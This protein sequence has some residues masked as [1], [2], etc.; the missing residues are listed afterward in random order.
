MSYLRSVCWAV[1]ESTLRARQ[2][3]LAEPYQADSANEQE[4]L[5]RS[6]RTFT[7][8][9]VPRCPLVLFKRGKRKWRL[10]SR[11]GQHIKRS[12]TESTTSLR[13]RFRKYLPAATQCRDERICR[14]DENGGW[15]R[16]RRQGEREG[17]VVRHPAIVEH[18]QNVRRI[19]RSSS[20]PARYMTDGRN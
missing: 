16:N 18:L 13:T 10:D 17:S 2:A 1:P 5:G 8:G 12:D 14:D 15:E 3:G 6:G 11:H 7:S 4:I 9:W 19:S 20:Q